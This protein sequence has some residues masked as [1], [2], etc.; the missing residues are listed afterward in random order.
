MMFFERVTHFFRV[1]IINGIKV[2]MSAFQ[3]TVPVNAG[4]WEILFNVTNGFMPAGRGC[5]RI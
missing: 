1:R 4:N 3:A 5:A 2:L